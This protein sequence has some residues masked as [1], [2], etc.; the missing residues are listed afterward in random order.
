MIVPEGLQKCSV[1]Q[2]RGQSLS[3]LDRLPPRR[4]PVGLGAGKKKAGVTAAWGWLASDKREGEGRV[5]RASGP[6][7]C[8]C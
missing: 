2:G 1:G 8:C 5:A 4:I 3:S 6:S 7:C